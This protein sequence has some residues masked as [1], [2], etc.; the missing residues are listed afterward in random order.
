MWCQVARRVPTEQRV[1][2]YS[3]ALLGIE[4]SADVSPDPRQDAPTV[5]DMLIAAVD[6]AGEVD[7][8][9]DEWV[10]GHDQIPSGAMTVTC[11]R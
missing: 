5:L 2:S 6:V 11:S 10:A 7:Q 1:A 9:S 8:Q 4:Q 3:S